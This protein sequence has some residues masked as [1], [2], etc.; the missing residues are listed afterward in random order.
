MP[1]AGVALD[2]CT[3]TS[4]PASRFVYGLTRWRLEGEVM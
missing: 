1:L 3:S 2:L 4:E